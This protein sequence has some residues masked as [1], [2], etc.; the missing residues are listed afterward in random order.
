MNNISGY[1]EHGLTN[2]NNH[3]SEDKAW[4]NRVNI[5]VNPWIINQCHN[6]N[7][8]YFSIINGMINEFDLYPL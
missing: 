6:N 7:V 3:E 8:T 1:V 4:N 5:K 2:Q